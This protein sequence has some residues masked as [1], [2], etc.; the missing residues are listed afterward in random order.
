MIDRIKNSIYLKSLGS[1][2]L[3]ELVMAGIFG[4]LLYT[5]TRQALSHQAQNA[6]E[7][8]RN[9]FAMIQESDAKMM[10]VALDNFMLSDAAWQ[11][12]SNKDRAKLSAMATPI[13]EKNRKRNNISHFYFIEPDGKCFLRVHD[14]ANYGDTIGRETFKRAAQTGKTT[15]GIE[16]GKTAFALRVVAPYM[17]DDAPTASPSFLEF[18]EEITHFNRLVKSKTGSDLVVLLDKKFVDEAGYN[19]IAG[20]QF[21]WDAFAKFAVASSTLEGD[22]KKYFDPVS[23]DQLAGVTSPKAFGFQKFGDRFL[24]MGGFP[25]EDVSGKRIGVV[26]VASDAT[27][28]VMKQR[29]EGLVFGGVTLLILGLSAVAA[30]YILRHE[31][32]GPILRLEKDANAIS[33]GEEVEALATNRTDEIG[34]LIQSFERMRFSL[35][36][37]MTMLA[38]LRA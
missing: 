8:T 33:L 10:S 17:R 12:Y 4:V 20:S 26:F 21:R 37:S 19:K 18:G 23:E 24:S 14:Q 35:K 5:S 16:L 34:L 3:V 36:K 32:I 7:S 2:V 1:I 30:S 29:R 38:K 27:P 22:S 13:F 31:L 6:L 11:A 9:A 15:S 25:L 28:Y